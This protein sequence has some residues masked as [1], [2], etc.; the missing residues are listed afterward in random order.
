M[1]AVDLGLDEIRVWQFDAVNGRLTPNDPPSVAV[2]PGDGPRHF[3]FHPNGRWLYSLQEEA[4]TIATF[5]PA[6]TS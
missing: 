2:P 5:S 4:S 3:A 6:R 1:L